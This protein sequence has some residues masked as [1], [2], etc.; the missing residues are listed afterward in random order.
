MGLVLTVTN[1][2][3]IG[4]HH[5]RKVQELVEPD[6]P[7]TLA[8][9]AWNL[10]NEGRIAEAR[11]LYEKPMAFHPDVIQAVLGLARMKE[12]DRKFLTRSSCLRKRKNSSRIIPAFI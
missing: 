11:Q 2:S 4:E 8:N 1:R 10:K 9:L 7:I 6:E 5:Y 3:I 12:A